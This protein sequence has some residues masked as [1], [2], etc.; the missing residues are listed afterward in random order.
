MVTE[1]P[2]G[3][4]EAAAGLLA[5]CPLSFGLVEAGVLPCRISFNRPMRSGEGASAGLV[6]PKVEAPKR[7]A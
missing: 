2:T 5:G 1:P 3:A 4:A 7:L 6:E